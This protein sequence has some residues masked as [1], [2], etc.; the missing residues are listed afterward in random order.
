MDYTKV[1]ISSFR[2]FLILL[3]VF[4]TVLQI[5]GVYV[6]YHFNNLRTTQRIILIN[7]SLCHILHSIPCFFKFSKIIGNIQM[8][9]EVLVLLYLSRFNYLLLLHYLFIDRMLEIYLHLKYPIYMTKKVSY[10][11]IVLLWLISLLLVFAVFLVT[12]CYPYLKGKLYLYIFPTMIWCVICT[13]LFVYSYIYRKW[14][15]LRRKTPGI[16]HSIQTNSNAF[17]GQFL[18]VVTFILFQGSGSVLLIIESTVELNASTKS[19]L[20]CVGF[21]LFAF[22]GISDVLMHI[23]LQRDI[24]KKLLL[25]FRKR[26]IEV[27]L[28]FKC[29]SS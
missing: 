7:L 25:K 1:D 22:G 8:P 16:N 3:H 12:Y 17:M 23:L 26:L 21:M 20:Q 28:Q 5:T 11:I 18:V 19:L 9:D 4:C 10:F 2:L 15:S 13:A 24:K 27:L 14:T 6:L 29:W